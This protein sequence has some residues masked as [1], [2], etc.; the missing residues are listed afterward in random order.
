MGVKS[1]DSG[2]GAN[3]TDGSA[4]AEGRAGTMK[5]LL[6]NGHFMSWPA[7]CSGTESGF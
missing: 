2:S 7:Y 1:C 4:A 3:A 5:L 6:H